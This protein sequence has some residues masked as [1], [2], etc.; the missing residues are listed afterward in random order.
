MQSQAILSLQTVADGHLPKGGQILQL[1]AVAQGRKNPLWMGLP[2]RFRRTR[3]RADLSQRQVAR[4]ADCTQFIPRYVEGGGVTSIDIVEKL[5][6]GL[7]VAPSWLAFGPEGDVPF[8]QKRPRPALPHEEPLPEPG[9]HK[10]TERYKGC[11]ER[12]RQVREQHGFSLRAVAEAANVSFQAVQ[13]TETGATVP[14]LDMLE[15]LAVALDVAPG[16][17]AYGDE[18]EPA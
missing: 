6:A 2:D 9:S 17:L 15:V 8:R 4:L 16:W 12:I 7:G 3:K 18:D 5:A 1:A 13:Y 14:K 10:Y 11:G